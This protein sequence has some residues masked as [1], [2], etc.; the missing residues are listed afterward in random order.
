MVCTAG[1]IQAEIIP[2]AEVAKAPRG[3][4]VFDAV[5]ALVGDRAG[6]G[7]VVELG[8]EE[9]AE[10]GALGEG[11]NFVVACF[12]VILAYEE[13]LGGYVSLSYLC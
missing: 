6:E 2:V 11:G 5:A 3:H 1:G 10:D 8:P 13:G 12:V 7:A 4:V 9:V